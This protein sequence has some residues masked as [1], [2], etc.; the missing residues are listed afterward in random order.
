MSSYEL[1]ELF[2]ARIDDDATT[3]TRTIHIDFA[4][5]DGAVARAMRGG[6]ATE[7]TQVC[8]Q[9]ANEMAVLR[10]GYVPNADASQYGSHFFLP[11]AKRQEIEAEHEAARAER[12]R[13]R[14]EV[15]EGGGMAAMWQQK[16]VS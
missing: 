15:P 5:E 16:E 13:M 8:R 3:M 11:L 7:L 14:D 10:A 12:E 2:G 4:P 6:E 1:L 9:T